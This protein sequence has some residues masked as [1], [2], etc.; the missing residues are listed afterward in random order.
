M[1]ALKKAG[2]QTVSLYQFWKFIK[3]G[4]PLPEKSVLITFDDSRT[5]SYY[6]ADPIL[7][8]LDFKAVMF[9]ITGRSTGPENKK[10][11]FHLSE[12]EILKMLETGRWEIGSHTQNGHNLQKIDRD[13]NRGHFLSNKLW[14][15]Q[16][17]RLETEEEYARRIGADLMASKRDLENNMKIKVIGFAYPFGDYGNGTE[18]F[19]GS[20]NV[21]TKEA[22]SIFPLSFRQSEESEF[23]GN[24]PDKN[25]SLVKRINVN[26]DLSKDGLLFILNSNLEKKLPYFDAFTANNGWV[27]GWGSFELK[28]G[29]LLTRAS[30]SEDSSLIFLSGT[31]D[32]TDYEIS[33]TAHLIQGNAFAA[34]ARYEDGNNYV[35]CDFSTS[36]ISLSQRINGIESVISESDQNFQ[37][38]SDKDISIGVG[39]SGNRAACYIEGKAVASGILSSSL[40][41]GGVG[42]KTWD[43][44]LNNSSILISNLEINPV[45]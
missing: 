18:N 15:D 24:Y 39:V 36:G 3:D 42:F 31:F 22:N 27:A 9:V 41:Q 35:S 32:W 34:V 10:N 4:E 19:P 43:N 37:I 21:L 38:A 33:A 25:S 5:D 30:S 26:S 17:G 14:L 13:G 2:Y 12:D 8:T 23:S 6:M 7:R 1:F 16:E 29:L 20:E 45:R 28:N 11:V 44:S 40:G